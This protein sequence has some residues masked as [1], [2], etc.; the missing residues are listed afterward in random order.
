METGGKT[1]KASSMGEIATKERRGQMVGLDGYAHGGRKVMQVIAPGLGNALGRAA[2]G[3]S[4]TRMAWQALEG[5]RDGKGSDGIDEPGSGML[6]SGAPSDGV[7]GGTFRASGGANGAFGDM[8]AMA[9]GT[10]GLEQSDVTM[11]SG[12]L[13]KELTSNAHGALDDT[14]GALRD[15]SKARGGSAQGAGIHGEGSGGD[16]IAGGSLCEIGCNL[17]EDKNENASTLVLG[18]TS[19]ELSG[20]SALGDAFSGSFDDSQ[21]SKGDASKWI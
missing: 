17:G 8:V 3:T 4:N 12:A 16:A 20:T 11:G 1:S 21:A 2:P 13:R 19:K 14:H 10:I 5:G 18:D 15:A 7:I 9:R 6:N